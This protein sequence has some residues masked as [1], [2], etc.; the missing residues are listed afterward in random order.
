[1]YRTTAMAAEAA[2]QTPVAPGQIEIRAR[3][4]LTAALR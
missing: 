4:T 2:P 1:M 3:V